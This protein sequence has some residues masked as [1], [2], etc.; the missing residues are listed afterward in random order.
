[1]KAQKLYTIGEVAEMTGVAVK[2]IRFYSDSGL[3]PPA[4][5]T[6]TRYRLYSTAEIWRLEIVRTLRHFGFSLE[7]IG[8]IIRGKVS[9]KTAIE[10]QLEALEIEIARL[11]QVRDLLKQAGNVQE[12]EDSLNYLHGICNAVNSS[13]EERAEFISRKF[14]RLMAVP[15]EFNDWGENLLQNARPKLPPNPSA[16]QAAAWVELIKLLDDPDFINN[17]RQRVNPF[18]ELL[19]EKKIDMQWWGNAMSQLGERTKTALT[20]GA[21]AA[22]PTI[23]T[24]IHDWVKLYAEMLGQTPDKT[25]VQ[26]FA[27]QV[28]DWY[29][30]R[31][32][33]IY[34]LMERAGWNEDEPSDYTLQKT[35]LEAL[36]IYV[37]KL[38]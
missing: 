23:Q 9:T 17:T 5:T 26:E 35:Y 13:V 27:A 4:G 33:K 10:W 8:K 22:S 24:I 34:E 7:E 2:T 11:L 12:E 14:S 21:T 36:Q 1:M 6:E 31:T 28:P 16:E 37:Q 25:F 20:A 3:I 30:Q 18:W 29:D 19:H 15:E 32:W 38:Q